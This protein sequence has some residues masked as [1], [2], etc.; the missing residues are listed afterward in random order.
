MYGLSWIRF[1][2]VA[3]PITQINTDMFRN[4]ISWEKM[5]HAGII[6]NW[7]QTRN[8]I[9]I[10]GIKS[11][12]TP[13][14]FLRLFSM[15]SKIIG[16]RVNAK[17]FVGKGSLLNCIGSSGKKFNPI[18]ISSEKSA[19]HSAI[20]LRRVCGRHSWKVMWLLFYESNC[21]L[22]HDCL[23]FE[24]HQRGDCRQKIQQDEVV[25]IKF[26]PI[27]VITVR[28]VVCKHAKSNKANYWRHETQHFWLRENSP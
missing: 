25:W 10:L 20:L 28:D 19:I 17:L 24:H 3:L 5:R 4:T 9:V 21:M 1:A 11:S 14:K 12:L 6:N 8:T 18:I 26:L 2:N 7:R 22:V 16:H 27:I 23:I 15:I 13:L